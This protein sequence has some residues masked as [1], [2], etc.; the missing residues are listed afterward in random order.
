MGSPHEPGHWSGVV[1]IGNAAKHEAIMPRGIPNPAAMYGIS[2]RAWGFEV[3][4]VRNGTRYYK[5]FGRASYGSEEQ[6]LL[7]AQDWRDDVVRSVPPVPRRTRAEKLRI[8]NT[9]GVSGVFAQVASSGKHPRVGRQDLHRTGRNTS[10]RL[11][12]RCTVGNCGA[13]A[14]H[15]GTVAATGAHGRPGQAAPGRGD[16]PHGTGGAPRRSRGRPSAPSRRSAG[17]PIRAA[18]AAFISRRPTSGTRATGWPSPTPRARA[19]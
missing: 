16:D 8:N 11:P 17:A 4:I 13:G 12:G 15:R 6:A 14:G 1:H 7:Q 9:T 5:Q 18:S 3:S 10:H 19:A 2:P